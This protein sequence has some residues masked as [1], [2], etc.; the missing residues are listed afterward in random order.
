MVSGPCW[1]LCLSWRRA[2]ALAG[3]VAL[4]ARARGW[5][6]RAAAPRGAL[7]WR[8]AELLAAPPRRCRLSPA[9]AACLVCLM[10][11][12]WLGFQGNGFKTFPAFYISSSSVDFTR[13]AVLEV[14]DDVKACHAVAS[15]F[16]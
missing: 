5:L 10:H 3:C 8:R 14:T 6:K 12:A 15:R 13:K 9:E 2:Q 16:I 7:R 1:E 4:S 11:L